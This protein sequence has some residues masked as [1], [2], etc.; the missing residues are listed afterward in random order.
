MAV[1]T[2]N[3]RNINKPTVV[4]KVTLTAADTL[5]YKQSVSQVLYLVNTTVGSL[6][7]TIDGDAGT[8]VSPKGLGGPVDVST[9]KEVTVAASEVVMVDLQSISAYCQGTVAVTGGTGLIAWI[10]EG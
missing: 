4:N 2:A 7:V 3:T 6:S 10:I 5:V 8:T 9:G 1:I